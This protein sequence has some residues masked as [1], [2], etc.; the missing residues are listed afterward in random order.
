MTTTGS[1]YA[2]SLAKGS[3]A[4]IRTRSWWRL[5]AR[6]GLGARGVVYALLAYFAVDIALRGHSP[7]QA[8]GQG[9][10]REIARQ[11]AGPALLGLL[12]VGLLSYGLWRLAEAAAGPSAS[13]GSSS[14]RFASAGMRVGWLASGAVYL[15]LFAQ[16][17]ALLTASGTGTGGPSSHPRPFVAT[18]LRWPA[19]PELVGLGAAGIMAGGL[20]LAIWAFAHDMA[21]KLET[22]H[23]SARTYL[24]ARLT[25]VF[26]DVT[27]GLLTGLIG[28][29]LMAGAVT[30]NPSQA[31]SLGQVLKSIAHRPYGA[32]LLGLAALGLVAFALY[33][34]VEA[35]YRRL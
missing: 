31:K 11:P 4:H 26:G 35:L 32:W 29:Y 1:G 28:V 20:A 23:M 10:L 18:A 12:S 27:R 7:A 16:A 2:A 3:F 22:Q 5:L 30:D 13:S 34:F 24:V 17:V 21:K 9:A 14:R 8:N 6:A 19:G 15:V 33:S 25:G